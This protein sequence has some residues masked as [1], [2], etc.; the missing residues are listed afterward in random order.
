[1]LIVALGGIAPIWLIAWIFGFALKKLDKTKIII[2][3][4]FAS[5][6]VAIIISGFGNANGGPWNPMI[7]EYALSLIFVILIRLGIQNFRNKS[8]SS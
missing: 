5:Y 7:I 8:S 3:S 4:S 6:I 1:M 2:Y